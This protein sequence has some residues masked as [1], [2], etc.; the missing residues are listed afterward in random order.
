AWSGGKLTLWTSN[1]MVAWA[2]QDLALTL[3]MRPEDIHVMSPYVGGGFGAKLFLRAEVLAALGARAA[4]R[5]VKV[6]L[7]RPQIPNNTVHRPATI[8]RIR[9]GADRTGRIDAIAHEVWCG[10]LAG[11]SPEWAAQQTRLLYA[12]ANRMTAHRLA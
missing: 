7:A 6:A 12:G 9:I 2:V 11:G 3:R 1:Q 4:G 10:N 5:P 8:Q